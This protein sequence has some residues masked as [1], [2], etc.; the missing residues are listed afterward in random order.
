MTMYGIIVIK[1]NMFYKYLRKDTVDAEL[2]P[3][4]VCRVSKCWAV[5]RNWSA[6]VSNI[7]HLLLTPHFPGLECKGKQM[8]N[9]ND[10]HSS[11]PGQLW[12]P[13]QRG[14]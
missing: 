12:F 8:N 9:I 7:S 4:R 3:T 2:K 13:S 10:V 5:L 14:L 6:I 1:K 11:L